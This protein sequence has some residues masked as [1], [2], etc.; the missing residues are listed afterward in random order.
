MD[1]HPEYYCSLTYEDWCDLLSAIEV[2]Y[3]RKRIAGH[4]KKIAPA[5]SA[6]ISDSEKSVR[7][8]RRKK[9]KTGVLGSHNSPRRAHDRHHGSHN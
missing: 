6:S 7:V 2:K 9:A 8:P 3:E 1:D 4:I 5:R